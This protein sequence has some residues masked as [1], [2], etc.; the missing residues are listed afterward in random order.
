MKTGGESW[1]HHY[2]SHT[3]RQ[4]RERDRQVVLIPVG[5]VEQHGD[6][7]PVGTDAWIA[8]HIAARV[9]AARDGVLVAD[10]MPYGSSGH[11]RQ[12]PGTL[13]LRPSTMIALAVDIASS[14]AQHGDVPVFINGHGGNRPPLGVA[15]QELLLEN[16]DAWSI[17]YFDELEPLVESL[18]SPSHAAVGHACAMETSIIAHLWPD[19]VQQQHLL[20]P[21]GQGAWPDPFLFPAPHPQTNRPFERVSANGVVGRPDLFSAEAGRTLVAAAVEKVGAAVVRIRDLALS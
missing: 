10:P 6:H 16:V 18:F 1:P 12:F 8:S 20:A 4:H 14:V 3:S 11:H 15:L 21:G 9:A 5:A 7:L 13:S 2:S 19:L 17:S